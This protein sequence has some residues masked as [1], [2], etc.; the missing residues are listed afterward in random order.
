MLEVGCHAILFIGTSEM[1]LRS[2]SKLL[3]ATAVALAAPL[4]CAQDGLPGALTSERDSLRNFST[5]FGQKLAIADFDKDQK[6]DGAVLVD[7]GRVSDQNTFRIEFHLSGSVNNELSFETSETALSIAALDVNHDGATD[8]VVEQPFTHKRLYVWLN[9][10]H[11]GFHKGRVEDY[12][13]A[14]LDKADQLVRP[15]SWVAYPAVCLPQH[16]AKD[17]RILATSSVWG[18]PPSTH[19]PQP[20]DFA[21]IFA[22]GP[23]SPDCSRAPPRPRSL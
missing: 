11:G 14:D 21:L 3:L 16:R 8:L 5:T 4:L 9:D 17:L 22:S 6:L 20:R 15:C 13:S 23:Y 12:P 18:R 19:A 10:G 1:D 7:S 2:L